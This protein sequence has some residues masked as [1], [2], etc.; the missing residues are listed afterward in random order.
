MLYESARSGTFLEKCVDRLTRGTS[1]TLPDGESI[2]SKD[3]YI[4]HMFRT[5]FWNT[6][7]KTY[8]DVVFQPDPL[9]DKLLGRILSEREL[10]ALMYYSEH[11][12][13]VFVGHYWMS[14]KPEPITSNV[15]CLDYSAVKYGKLVAYRMD[16]EAVLDPSK[17]VWQDVTPS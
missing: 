5:K 10:D 15:A 17:F 11:D 6:A 4:R 13:P 14:G 3:G 8:S 16:D 9:P 2:V 12:K 7:P 1:L